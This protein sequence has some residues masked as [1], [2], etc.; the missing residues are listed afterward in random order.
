MMKLSYCTLPVDLLC[1]DSDS[2]FGSNNFLRQTHKQ[3]YSIPY[4]HRVQYIG[5]RPGSISSYMH[6]V[7]TLTGMCYVFDTL[8]G[9]DLIVTSNPY[10]S[11]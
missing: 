5:R 7:H 4:I 6:G 11:N 8:T 3:T 9:L 1:S 10:L 2:M